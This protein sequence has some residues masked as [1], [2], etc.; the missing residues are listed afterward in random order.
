MRAA[1][2]PGVLALL[3]EYASLADPVTE[4][5]EACTRA[6]AD[7]GPA[8]IVASDQGRR[9]ALGLGAQEDPHAEAVLVVANGSAMRTEK[10]PGHFD[11]RAEAFDDDLRA[12]LLVGAELAAL[13]HD[14]AVA[15][16][17]DVVP[18]AALDG[19]GPPSRVLYDDAPYGVQYWVLVWNDAES[20]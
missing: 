5:R 17:A 12:R 13:D 2:I 18:L 16:W 19:A 4:L 6:I 15:L 8:R 11:E 1:L 20:A 3:P 7:L 14:L 9:V 10:A